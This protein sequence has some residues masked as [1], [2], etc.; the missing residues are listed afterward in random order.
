MDNLDLDNEI[1][2][3]EQKLSKVRDEYKNSMIYEWNAI[4]D[5]EIYFIRK[6]YYLNNIKEERKL[7]NRYVEAPVVIKEQEAKVNKKEEKNNSLDCTTNEE[8]VQSYN[9]EYII[10]DVE[11]LESS[12]QLLLES[13]EEEEEDNA[14]S[15]IDFINSLGDEELCNLDNAMEGLDIITNDINSQVEA[16]IELMDQESCKYD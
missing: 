12:Q 7:E 3:Y 13:Y 14:Q 8:V 16:K 10:E 2:Y 6:I 11:Q 5:K 9:T 1:K 4:R 15:Y